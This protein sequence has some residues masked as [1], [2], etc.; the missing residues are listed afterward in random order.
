MHCY[1]KKAA[2][3]KF[4]VGVTASIILSDPMLQQLLSSK[5]LLQVVTKLIKLSKVLQEYF[6]VDKND[7]VC[8]KPCKVQII[9]T[10]EDEFSGDL[11]I[12]RLGI[13]PVSDSD[14]EETNY[15]IVDIDDLDITLNPNMV[16]ILDTSSMEIT[17]KEADN[18]F[19][20]EIQNNELSAPLKKFLKIIESGK[21]LNART[22]ISEVLKDLNNLLIESQI[23]R[24]SLIPEMIIRELARDIND[25]HEKSTEVGKFQFIRLTSAIMNSG[26]A[27]VALSFEQHT[28]LLEGPLFK[29]HKSSPLDY[30]F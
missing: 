27:S 29:K 10:T 15:S 22:S 19:R 23:Y 20:M 18:A 7:I 30:I 11:L 16:E 21:E 26:S 5:H 4:H 12:T 24:S 8:I 1:G 28:K 3:M 2:S 13:A 14:E 6:E 25:L 17:F 9:E